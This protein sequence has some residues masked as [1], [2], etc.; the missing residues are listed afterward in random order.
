M[1]LTNFLM[2][3]PVVSSIQREMGQGGEHDG[4]V[5]LDGVFGVVEDRAGGQVGF[6]HVEAFLDLEQSL[7]GTD[8][9]LGGVP[10]QHEQEADKAGPT[11]ATRRTHR[12]TTS[13]SK[14]PMISETGWWAS[15]QN[16]ATPGT[17]TPNSLVKRHAKT[18]DRD[19]QE[20]CELRG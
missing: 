16:G 17:R 18:E 6:G 2:E 11:V 7:V 3:Q 20:E 14:N 1:V 8:H 19:H 15:I 13:T 4:Q 10:G 12:S 5:C 9:K